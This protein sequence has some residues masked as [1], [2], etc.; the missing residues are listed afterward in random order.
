MRS[1]LFGT[2]AARTAARRSLR[3]VGD[4]A[5]CDKPLLVGFAAHFLQRVGRQRDSSRLQYFLQT[6]LRILEHLGRRQFTQARAQQPFV[7]INC[8]AIPDNLLE[9]TLFGYEKGAF[10]G[11]QAAQSGKFEQANGGTLLLDEISEMPLQLQA[12]LLRVLQEKE[13]RRV[14]DTTDIPI[15]ARVLA[16]TNTRLETLVKASQFREDLFYRLSVIPIEIVPLRERREDIPPLIRHILRKEGVADGA[17]A[18]DGETLDLLLR[19]EWPGNVRELEN[20]VER[21][22]ILSQGEPLAFENLSRSKHGVPPIAAGQE[23]EGLELDAFVSD[24]IRRVLTM[25]DG[26]V[27]GKGGAAELLG[28]NPSTLRYRMNRLGIPYGRKLTQ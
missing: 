22:L 8:A 13:V 19:H 16:A 15:D 10:T 17:A 27:H 21:A 6:R 25:T 11:A 28:I 4:L 3:E 2:P 5:A 9:S 26:R 23:A 18:M 7:A 1:F 20:L 24:H 14:G 12:K